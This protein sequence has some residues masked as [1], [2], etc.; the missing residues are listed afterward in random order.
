[1]ALISSH[2]QTVQEPPQK[3]RWAR[4]KQY[5]REEY[6]GV[7]A[8]DRERAALIAKQAVGVAA[9]QQPPSS[10]PWGEVPSE[11]GVTKQ[12][13]EEEALQDDHV[14]RVCSGDGE[15]NDDANDNT[16]DEDEDEEDDEDGDDDPDVWRPPTRGAPVSCITGR[17]RNPHQGSSGPAS[18][19]LRAPRSRS[20]SK[21]PSTTPIAL[22]RARN[23]R[24]PWQSRPSPNGSG[25][26]APA[27]S[28]RSRLFESKATP[29]ASAASPIACSLAGR[30]SKAAHGVSDSD[31]ELMATLERDIVERSPGVQWADVA[32]LKDAKRVLEEA[33]VLPLWMPEYFQG[34]RRPWKGVLMFGPP[35]TGKTLL[36]KAVATECNTT[37]FNVSTSTLASKWRGESER[38]VRTLFEMARANAPSTIF[39]DEIDS[40]CTA[41]G[42]QGE[43]EASRRLKSELL[44][45]ID[46]CHGTE[47]NVMVLAA[48]NFPWDL[49]EALRRRLE[50]RIYIALPDEEARG[51]LLRINLQSVDVAD[52]VDYKEFARLLVGYSCDDIT[53]VCRDACLSGMRRKIAG[54][55]PEQIKALS[56]EDVADPVT[57]ADCREA[58]RKISP[59]VSQSDVARHEQWLKEFGSS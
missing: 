59:S 33:V 56:K 37:F 28:N 55:T 46:G 26:S 42:S 49:D 51:E 31:P 8:L 25:G 24:S 20:Q 32:G 17:A 30:D 48:T 1:M 58:I 39:I 18:S 5:L 34:I 50:K 54:M 9:P 27:K 41:R 16:N 13:E 43:H 36:A 47:S 57:M 52:D 53:N 11:T 45:Q 22:S 7:Q 23:A 44:V 15:S 2:L 6:D 4:C 38:L 40:M 21:A 35:G 19:S 12:E 29:S 14:L 10:A 3:V